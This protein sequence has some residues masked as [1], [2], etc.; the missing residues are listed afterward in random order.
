LYGADYRERQAGE[1]RNHAFGHSQFV[2]DQG[3]QRIACG[4][5][6]FDV[7]SATEHPALAAQ[8]QSS[9]RAIA[10]DICNDTS[11]HVYDRRAQRIHFFWRVECYGRDGTILFENYRISRHADVP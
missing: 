4:H 11:E 3:R 10:F 7:A 8:Q 1:L 5:H 6:F 9:N 2:I